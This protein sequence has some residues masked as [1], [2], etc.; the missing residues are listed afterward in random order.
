LRKVVREIA[1]TVEKGLFFIHTFSGALIYYSA[2]TNFI[3]L[4]NCFSDQCEDK[5]LP[6]NVKLLWMEGFPEIVR[7]QMSMRSC[8][9]GIYA[10]SGKG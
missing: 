4:V 7:E 3:P 2:T 6:V 5:I 10:T 9:W 8:K 1:E